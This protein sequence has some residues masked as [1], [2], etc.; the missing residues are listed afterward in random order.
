MTDGFPEAPAS[1]SVRCQIEGFEW[2]I[3]IREF[4][5][6]SPGLVLLGKLKAVNEKIVQ[7][8]GSPI[9]GRGNGGAKAEAAPAQ[10]QQTAVLDTKVCELHNALM[11]KREK[12]GEV[13]YSH[14]LADGSY[15]N[16]QSKS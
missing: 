16:G 9:F 6:E 12:S 7:M 10:G 11:K 5:T 8:G 15:C 14:K 4:A 1:A 3:T 2:L 13:W